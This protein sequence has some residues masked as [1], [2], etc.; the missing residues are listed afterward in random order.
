MASPVLIII[1]NRHNWKWNFRRVLRVN[2]R[3]YRIVHEQHHLGVDLVE[4]KNN[5]EENNHHP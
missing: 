4:S 1:A 5:E 2:V 3:C